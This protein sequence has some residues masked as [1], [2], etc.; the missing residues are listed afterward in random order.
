MSVA[1]QAHACGDY[2]EGH[3]SPPEEPVSAEAQAEYDAQMAAWEDR[4]G[5]G[6]PPDPPA[7]PAIPGPPVPGAGM[8]AARLGDLTAHGGTIGPVVTGI[9]AGVVANF[10]PVACMGDPHLCPMFDGPKPH[11]GGVIAKGSMSVFVG[12]MPAARVSDIT[13]CKGPPGAVALGDVSVVIG[14]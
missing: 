3:P 8:P 12:G 14:E 11:V 9:A 7:P 2:Y 4:F 5:E 6:G 13:E 10:M 1:D